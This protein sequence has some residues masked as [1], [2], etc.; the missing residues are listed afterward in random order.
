[1]I[2]KDDEEEPSETT[3]SSNAPTPLTMTTS[4][5]IESS[6]TI[7]EDFE[8]TRQEIEPA[9]VR[10]STRDRKSTP[11]M[12]LFLRQTEFRCNVFFVE[13][14]RKLCVLHLIQ[15][16]FSFSFFSQRTRIQRRTNFGIGSNSDFFLTRFRSESESN[17][18]QVRSLE[19]KLTRPALE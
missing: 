1:M 4:S 16:S 10:R 17:Q 2:Y 6:R 13:V 14:V 15:K 11:K 9:T 12:A 18:N 7:L 8:K 19:K 3:P 5:Q